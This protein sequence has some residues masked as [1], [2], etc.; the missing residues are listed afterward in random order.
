MGMAKSF[1]SCSIMEYYDIKSDPEANILRMLYAFD[2][3][4][5]KDYNFAFIAFSDVIFGPSFR[6]NGEKFAELLE[7]W[8]LP[9]MESSIETNPNTGNRVRFWLF[10]VGNKE[11]FLKLIAEKMPGKTWRDHDGY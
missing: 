9:K 4:L 10:H 1:T 11:T 6:S 2:R 5:P 8:G 3:E 7:S